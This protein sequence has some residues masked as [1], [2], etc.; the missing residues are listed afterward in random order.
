MM[1]R[2]SALWYTRRVYIVYALIYYFILTPLG[3]L[4]RLVGYD[5]LQLRGARR[6]ESAFVTRD[7]A[8]TKKD[9]EHA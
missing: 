2:P 5:P 3:L 7:G 1:S 9:F 8:F 6:R 4:F